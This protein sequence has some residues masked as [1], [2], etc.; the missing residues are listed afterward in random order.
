L[1]ASRSRSLAHPAVPTRWKARRST[2]MSD[3]EPIIESVGGT[4]VGISG[5]GGGTPSDASPADVG[6]TTA[7]GTSTDYSRGDHS[8]K[9]AFGSDAQGDIAIRGATA[10][11]R[12]GAGTAGQSLITGGAAANPAWGFPAG[13]TF[14][15]DARGD[16]A[17]R[18]ASAYARFAIGS[19]GTF[20][21]SNGTD[22]AWTS[23]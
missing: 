16:I 8:H 1:R 9:I 19:A 4:P 6:A 10:Y 18:G 7:A 2:N 23:T 22:P 20:L 12:L 21:S 11:Q 13:L 17:V 14:G 3:T 5:S 15:S